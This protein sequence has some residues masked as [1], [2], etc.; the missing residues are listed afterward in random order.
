MTKKRI[1]W[2]K[3]PQWIIS[4]F[5]LAGVTTG[6][7]VNLA[8]FIEL[9]EVTEA[10]AGQVRSNDNR[11]SDVERYIQ[12]QQEANDLQREWQQQ[13]QVQQQPVYYQPRQKK[14]QY[15]NNQRNQRRRDIP[16]EYYEDEYYEDERGSM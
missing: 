1:E 2:Y 12:V 5:A 3:R 10:L 13:Q 4:M 6:G 11:V 15:Y 8:D 16:E 14:S 9:P 7:V